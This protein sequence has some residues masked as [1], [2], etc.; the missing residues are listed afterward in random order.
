MFRPPSQDND[1]TPLYERWAEALRLEEHKDRAANT[2]ETT[3]RHLASRNKERPQGRPDA[4]CSRKAKYL[5]VRSG[6]RKGVASMEGKY[7]P[8]CE[9][10]EF[11]YPV[12]FR[13]FLN[14]KKIYSQEQLKPSLITLKIY[15]CHLI[16]YPHLPLF[17]EYAQA[18]TC[19][20]AILQFQIEA[21]KL[22]VLRRTETKMAKSLRLCP[23]DPKPDLTS[24][25]PRSGHS[26]VRFT[27]LYCANAL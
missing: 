24:K 13:T 5:G 16:W 20:P 19:L 7:N 15:S 23:P 4:S 22:A 18:K 9:W 27:T 12:A 3:A 21:E 1:I 2:Q 26:T 11:H 10:L 14:V 25:F 6:G 17:E 8:A